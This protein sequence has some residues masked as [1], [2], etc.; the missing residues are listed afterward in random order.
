MKLAQAKEFHGLGA[1]QGWRVERWG[2]GWVVV[3]VGLMGQRCY[4]ETARGG[5]RVFKTLDAAV[6]EVV[7]I[8]FQ[9]GALAG[10]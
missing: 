6:C 10:V 5:E 9:V 7:S 4:L 3:L 8:G 2:A 1:F